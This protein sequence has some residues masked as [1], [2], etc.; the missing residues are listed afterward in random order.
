MYCKCSPNKLNKIN[1]NW[2]KQQIG[3]SVARL[4]RLAFYLNFVG[5]CLA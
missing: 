1:L 5:L 3:F 2:S 4:A